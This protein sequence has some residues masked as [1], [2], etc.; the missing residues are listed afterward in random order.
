MYSLIFLCWVLLATFGC[1]FLEP[2][3]SFDMREIFSIHL[4]QAGIQVDNTCDHKMLVCELQARLSHMESTATR[5]IQAPSEVACHNILRD[6]VRSC[7]AV[8]YC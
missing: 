1:C 4:G 8:W 2:S 7:K 6:W 5:P 3:F